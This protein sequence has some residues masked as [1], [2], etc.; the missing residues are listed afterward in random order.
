MFFLELSSPVW[1]S[2]VRQISSF[3]LS[4]NGLVCCIWL[5]VISLLEHNEDYVITFPSTYCRYVES[6]S[7]FF[8]IDLLLLISL[9]CRF[10]YLMIVSLRYA[11]A[12]N[13]FCRAMVSILSRSTGAKMPMAR[14][15]EPLLKRYD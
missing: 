2:G 14:L 3:I 8:I 6:G 4:T 11:S 5:G 7:L 13:Q 1:C 12:V 10:L 15:N 9:N